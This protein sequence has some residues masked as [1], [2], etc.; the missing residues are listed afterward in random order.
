MFFNY[1]IA[2]FYKLITHK[3]GLNVRTKHNSN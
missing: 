3:R 1:I 2:K